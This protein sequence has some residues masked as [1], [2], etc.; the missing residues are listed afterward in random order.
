MNGM[1]KCFIILFKMDFKISRVQKKVDNSHS[2]PIIIFQPHPQ[3]SLFTTSFYFKVDDVADVKF[4]KWGKGNEDFEA[5]ERMGGKIVS[6]NYMQDL[7]KL[8]AYC[9][10][11]KRIE[12]LMK[13]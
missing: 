6:Q 5:L 4:N 8:F 7:G 13:N 9:R 10:F 2:S 12:S 3:T 1:R 11:K